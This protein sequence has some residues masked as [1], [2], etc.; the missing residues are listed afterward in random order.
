MKTLGFCL[1]YLCFALSLA[2]N[3]MLR[4]NER[5]LR[6][7]VRKNE[8]QANSKQEI[9]P[10]K[11]ILLHGAARSSRRR[12][13]FVMQPGNAVAFTAVVSPPRLTLLGPGQTVIFDH[14]ITN[15]GNAYKN[16]TGVFR[17]PVTG[18]YVFNFAIMM[19]PGMDEY[20][21]LVKDG[22]HVMWNYGHAPGSTHL[23]SASRTATVELRAGQDV[24][25]RT[26][27]SANHGGG[28]IHGNGYTT[29]SGWLLAMT[30]E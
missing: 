15:V 24:W 9:T 8:V 6:G 18:V 13:R 1:L 4:G 3:N 2:E 28:T 26:A 22:Q 20:I 12:E 29:F 30:E 19:D 10:L 5:L 16:A 25:V 23:I 17:A 21:E 7:F 14:V 11:K 27:N